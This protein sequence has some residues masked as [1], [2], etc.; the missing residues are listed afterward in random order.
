[1]SYP[2]S[3]HSR[4]S[5]RLQ[6]D[7]DRITENER[8]N[9][10][11]KHDTKSKGKRMRH[12]KTEWQ[13]DTLG[14]GGK[15]GR[16]QRDGVMRWVSSSC[17]IS[18][19]LLEWR[20]NNENGCSGHKRTHTS[21]VEHA[22]PATYTTPSSSADP[23]CTLTHGRVHALTFTLEGL[24]HGGVGGAQPRGVATQNPLQVVGGITEE[25]IGCAI[26]CWAEQA[27]APGGVAKHILQESVWQDLVHVILVSPTHGRCIFCI[28]TDLYAFQ[29]L[30]DATLVLH[31]HHHSI[32]G[33]GCQVASLKFVQ[34]RLSS[35]WTQQLQVLQLQIQ[36]P[37]L[38][39]LPWAGEDWRC[40]RCEFKIELKTASLL[41]SIEIKFKHKIIA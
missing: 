15:G 12:G 22:P 35:I 31:A 25:Q 8:W 27:E 16:R 9:A 23:H 2:A 5:T 37:G 1:M 28:H 18:R 32:S 19:S 6:E 17:S 33:D 34:T 26:A 38:L 20:R 11:R 24:Q 13:R 29:E 3:Q 7:K 21:N 39:V 14:K 30:P 4:G 40:V 10:R 36:G 41:S